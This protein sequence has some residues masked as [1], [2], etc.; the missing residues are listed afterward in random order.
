MAADNTN[1][2]TLT[3]TFYNGNQQLCT[4]KCDYPLE[5]HRLN[6]AL[7]PTIKD[8]FASGVHY[9]LDISVPHVNISIAPNQ[10]DILPKTLLDA[11]NICKK[12]KYKH[13][14]NE[15]QIKR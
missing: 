14:A 4:Q 7:C 15:T 6:I 10:N 11:E 12:C 5:K 8:V 3:T 9:A 2:I 13:L 1:S